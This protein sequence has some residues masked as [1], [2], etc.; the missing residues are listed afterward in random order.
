MKLPSPRLLLVVLTA[1]GLASAPARAQ[2]VCVFDPAGRTGFMYQLMESWKTQ[3]AGWG[4]TVTLRPYTD[5]ATAINDY[6]A[7]SCDGVAASGVR[8]QKYNP[9]TY[10]VEAVGGITD[11]TL[12]K[13]VLQTLQ[14]KDTY[15]KLFTKGANETVGVFPIGA[16]YVYLRDRNLDT[17]PEMSGKRVAVLDYDQASKVAVDRMGGVASRNELSSLG[18][19][20]NNGELDVCFLPATAYTPFELWHGIGAK[21]GV[22]EYPLSQVTLQILL[23]PA[24]FPTGMGAKSRTWAASQFDAALAA[25]KRAEAEIPAATW[26]KTTTGARAEFD[27]MAQKLRVDLKNQGSYDATVL[28]LLKK[29]RCNADATR[30]ECAQTLE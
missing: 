13:R 14:T 21:G 3:A 9:A 29:A 17:V 12:F 10:T 11:Y 22:L 23:R 5:E 1:I 27:T 15:S 30:T 28:S 2:T 6:N 8:L 20:F 7:G 16:V 25:V 19:A 26:V 4:A 18:P 24:K